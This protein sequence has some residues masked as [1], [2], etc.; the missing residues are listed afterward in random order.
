M[1]N[2]FKLK[3][4][5]IVLLIVIG[6]SFFHAL[7]PSGKLNVEVVPRDAKIS[8]NDRA[9]RIGVNKISP[10]NIKVKV[11][12]IGFK[13][14]EQ[15]LSIK[16][17]ETRYLGVALESNSPSTA[18]WYTEHPREQK[19]AEAVSSK[20]FDLDTVF[21]AEK[22]PLIKILPQYFHYFSIG[23]GASPQYPKDPT[24]I[25]IIVKAATPFNRRL[26]LRWIKDNGYE[27][28]DYEIVFSG[29]PNPFGGD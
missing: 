6:Y 24:H 9:V 12:R 19:L 16:R 13:D 1:S 2:M 22:Y 27:P 28:S 17:G 10:G 3:L 26:A 15:S 20:N 29:A 18:N 5:A 21:Q 25:A 4:A 11:T 23:Y 8:I 14:N 7:R